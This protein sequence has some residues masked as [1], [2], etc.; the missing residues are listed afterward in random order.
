MD[1]AAIPTADSNSNEI[2]TAREGSKTPKARSSDTVGGLVH[3]NDNRAP[4][5]SNNAR[6]SNTVGGFGH[7]NGNGTPKN[8]TSKDSTN[9]RS[10]NT[11]G[12]FVHDNG[13]GTPKD[14]NNNNIKGTP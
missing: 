7:D 9:A 13:N 4:K 14:F 5:D 3:D 12:G 1:A 11:V 8:K 10:S 6:S 2:I